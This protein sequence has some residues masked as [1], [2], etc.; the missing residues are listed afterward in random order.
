MTPTAAVLRLIG[1]ISITAVVASGLMAPGDTEPPAGASRYRSDT[2]RV[3]PGVSLTRMVDRR[4]PNRINV[5]RVDLSRTTVD[6]ALAKDVLPG[7]QTTSSMGRQK[8][9]VAAVNGDYFLTHGHEWMGR[10]VNTYAEDGELMASPMIWGRNVAHTQ[11]EA[12]SFLGHFPLKVSITEYDTGRVHKIKDW[13]AGPPRPR[14]LAGYTSAGGSAITPPGQTCAARLFPSTDVQWHPET[15]GVIQDLTVDKARCS[16]EPM[17]R[18]GGIVVAGELTSAAGLGLVQSLLPGET[19]RLSWSLGFPEVLETLGGNPLLMQDGRLAVGPCE[20]S[21]FCLRH[22]RTGVG[23]TGDGRLLLAVVDGRWKR[24]VGMTPAQFA[25][26]FRYLGARDAINLD[27][28]GSTT[29]WVR[30][31]IVNRPSDGHERKVGNALLVLAH[32]D[33]EEPPMAASPPPTPPPYV[34]PTPTPTPTSS[35]SGVLGELPLPPPHGMTTRLSACLAARDPA[36]I[37]GYLDYV[38][39]RRGVSLPSPLRRTVS[40]FRGASGSSR[41]L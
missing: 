4:G 36:S 29:M 11:D 17:P 10:P 37:G 39:G 1:A 41:C 32:P 27:G 21:S 14:Q 2:R 12:D 34:P 7:L 16:A 40:A 33:P 8:G 35:P 24:S 3:A 6:V 9:A 15:E 23:V 31:Q 25:R 38:L 26:L 5:L 13:N 30:G 20:G 19:V 22:P 28:G 18:R